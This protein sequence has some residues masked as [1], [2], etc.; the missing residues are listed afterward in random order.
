MNQAMR[1]PRS[2]SGEQG[3]S[4][5]GRA[6]A[7]FT[8]GLALS[9]LPTLSALAAV[10]DVVACGTGGAAGSC[11]ARPSLPSTGSG[12]GSGS[13]SSDTGSGGIPCEDG[14]ESHAEHTRGACSHH[15]G[16]RGGRHR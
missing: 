2:G 1:R 6:V 10:P 9:L 13:G 8:A 7:V 12:S 14:T 3:F 4:S 16:I 5:P 15:G 11:V